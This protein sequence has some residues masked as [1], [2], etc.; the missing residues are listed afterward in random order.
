MNEYKLID[1]SIRLDRIYKSKLRGKLHEYE[2]LRDV[3]KYYKHPPLWKLSER[4][5]DYSESFNISSSLKRLKRKFIL[6]Y[7]DEYKIINNLSTVSALPNKL[8]N[9]N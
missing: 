8:S 2:I 6:V 9:Y 7:S 5:N 1:I 4:G 3:S